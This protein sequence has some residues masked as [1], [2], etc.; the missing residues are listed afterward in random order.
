[1]RVI[2]LIIILLIIFIIGKNGYSGYVNYHPDDTSYSHSSVTGSVPYTSSGFY[3]T[4]TRGNAIGYRETKSI[5][6]IVNQYT[7]AAWIWMENRNIPANAIVLQY[8]NGYP[9][10]YCRVQNSGA[11]YYGQLIPNQG[12]RVPDISTQPMSA[13][14]V[15]VK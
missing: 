13:Y 2:P 6:V 14:Q 9:I 8:V 4:D 7:G 5:P 1:M 15:L 3:Y 12:C 10:F 11:F